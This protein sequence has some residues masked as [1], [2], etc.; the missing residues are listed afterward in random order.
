MA[1][2]PRPGDL[3][4]EI[5]ARTCPK[6]LDCHLA[7]NNALRWTNE[8]ARHRGPFTLN[9]ALAASPLLCGELTEISR[10]RYT[11]KRA[12]EAALAAQIATDFR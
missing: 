9:A 7:R 10:V 12:T 2:P 8:F 1:P 11:T 3:S 4:F 6:G 5:T